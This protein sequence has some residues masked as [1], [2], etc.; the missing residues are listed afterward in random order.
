M[1]WGSWESLE[2]TRH[3]AR[4]FRQGKNVS[5][6]GVFDDFGLIRFGSSKDRADPA[7]R[8]NDE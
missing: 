8:H 2:L 6:D 7:G 3:P 4:Y 5:R 1:R